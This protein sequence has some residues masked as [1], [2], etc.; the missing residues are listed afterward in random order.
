MEIITV[1]KEIVLTEAIEQAIR[2]YNDFAQ[3]Q[4]KGNEI[5]RHIHQKKGLEEAP[6]L[7]SLH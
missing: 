1:P 4:D 7:Q 3:K 6:S 5:S 2:E